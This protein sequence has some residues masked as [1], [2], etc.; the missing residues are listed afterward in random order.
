MS[1]HQSESEY[2]LIY[3]APLII[4]LVSVVVFLIVNEIFKTKIIGEVVE[5]LLL[6][7]ITPSNCEK[8]QKLCLN[9]TNR[10]AKIIET[11]F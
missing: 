2:K 9:Q 3:L 6:T 4:I 11:H 5:E 1:S 10:I 7:K 8:A